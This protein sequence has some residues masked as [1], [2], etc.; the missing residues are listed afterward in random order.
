ML[1]EVI[2]ALPSPPS[3]GVCYGGFLKELKMSGSHYSDDSDQRDFAMW[4]GRVAS[5]I[6]GKRGQQCFRDMLSQMDA[7]PEKVLIA[8]DWKN[9]DGDVCAMG[10]CAEFRKIDISKVDPEEPY[11]VAKALNIAYSLA[12]EIACMND[13]WPTESPV[14]RFKRMRKWISSQIKE[15][16]Q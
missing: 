7:M 4:R 11:E 2:L 15:P 6:R 12:C 13:D 5:A 10:A 8:H 3:E 14:E 9:A 16:P 1:Y